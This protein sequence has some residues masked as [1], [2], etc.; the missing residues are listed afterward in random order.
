MALS[1]DITQAFWEFGSACFQLLNVRAIRASKGISGVHWIP[2]AF[3]GAWGVYNLWFYTVLNLP[4][5]YWA[6]L[7]ITLVNG[8]WLGHVA[9]YTRGNWYGKCKLWFDAARSRVSRS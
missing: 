1:P 5:A 3:F 7:F 8:V 9:Y 6:G 4:L 2:T